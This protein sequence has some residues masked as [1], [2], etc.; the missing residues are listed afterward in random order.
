MN[1][2]NFALG[3][4]VNIA[5]LLADDVLLVEYTC[6]TNN[7][8]EVLCDFSKND[9]QISYAI[10]NIVYSLPSVTC[11]NASSISFKIQVD[12]AD[13][14]TSSMVYIDNIYLYYGIES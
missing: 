1:I 11:N 12:S 13:V 8:F 4:D 14:N 3:I 5:K 10:S 6:D 2:K 7:S 9:Y